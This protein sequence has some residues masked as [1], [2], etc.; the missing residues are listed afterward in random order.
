VLEPERNNIEE[1]PV[2][3]SYLNP[4]QPLVTLNL[5]TSVFP[6]FHSLLFLCLINYSSWFQS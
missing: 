3:L 1:I 5:L 6:L 4:R 2:N